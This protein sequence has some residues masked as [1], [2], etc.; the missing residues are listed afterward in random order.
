MKIVCRLL[1][2]F[3]H[4][5]LI[6]FTYTADSFCEFFAF[7]WIQFTSPLREWLKDNMQTIYYY[8]QQFRLHLTACMAC[9]MYSLHDACTTLSKYILFPLSKVIL[10]MSIYLY[11]KVLKPV[12]RLAVYIARMFSDRIYQCFFLSSF[13]FDIRNGRAFL[14][15]SSTIVDQ[16]CV[17]AITNYR[18]CFQ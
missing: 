14:C 8:S 17:Y 10:R 12:S 4:Y 7:C 16:C 5:A 2:K 9:T 11:G 18:Q 6:C 1:A 3:L 13:V 15:A